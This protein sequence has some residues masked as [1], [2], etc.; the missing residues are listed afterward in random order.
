[1]NRLALV[2]MSLFGL[3]LAAHAA[4]RPAARSAAPHAASWP[5]WRPT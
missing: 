1:M 2:L 4:A 5:A 3:S